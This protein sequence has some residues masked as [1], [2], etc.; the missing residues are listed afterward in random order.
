MVKATLNIPLGKERYKMIRKINKRSWNNSQNIEKSKTIL[1]L[2]NKLIGKD[3][4]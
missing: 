4:T 3:L 1:A 2:E